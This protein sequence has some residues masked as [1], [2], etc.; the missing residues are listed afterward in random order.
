MQPSYA[1]TPS[2]V[3]QHQILKKGY[4][5]RK[6]QA[7]SNPDSNQQSPIDSFSHLRHRQLYKLFLVLSIHHPNKNKHFFGGASG[8]LAGRPGRPGRTTAPAQPAAMASL[9][10]RSV[11]TMKKMKKLAYGNT[12]LTKKPRGPFY[13]M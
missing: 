4:I 11:G 2:Q 10:S 12:M 9:G 1:H 8:R 6:I 7:I 5:H 3:M 13:C